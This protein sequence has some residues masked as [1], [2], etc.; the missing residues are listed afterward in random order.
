VLY[1]KVTFNKSHL[2]TLLH[3][4]HFIIFKFFYG[5]Q[6]QG[7]GGQLHPTPSGAAMLHNLRWLDLY[8]RFLYLTQLCVILIIYE[9]NHLALL[10]T[11][12][13]RIL[14]AKKPD[15]KK[16]QKWLR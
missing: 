8:R 12:D 10:R 13:S 3:R 14:H 2:G 1:C 4:E 6:G 16:Q 9:K 11:Q 15:A 5:G 7:H